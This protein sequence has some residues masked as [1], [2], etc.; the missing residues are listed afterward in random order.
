MGKQDDI[1]VK[2]IEVQLYA[3]RKALAVI[4]AKAALRKIVDHYRTPEGVKEQAYIIAATALF[5]LEGT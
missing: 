3:D 5:D 2:L 1:A 4:Q